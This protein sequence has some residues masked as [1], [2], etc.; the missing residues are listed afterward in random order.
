MPQHCAAPVSRL[1]YAVIRG[2]CYQLNNVAATLAACTMR[3]YRKDPI[4]STSAFGC[5]CTCVFLKHPCYYLSTVGSR[6]TAGLPAKCASSTFWILAVVGAVIACCPNTPCYI[7]HD[8]HFVIQLKWS[9]SILGYCMSAEA[10][11]MLLHKLSIAMYVR[12]T[13]RCILRKR[14]LVVTLILP[15]AAID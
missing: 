3:C 10:A 6:V 2:I 4:C 5:I 15:W 1:G 13:R 7:R 9:A 11:R 8:V 14:G 12:V